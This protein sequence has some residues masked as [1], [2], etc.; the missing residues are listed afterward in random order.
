MLRVRIAGNAAL[1]WPTLLPLAVIE[2]ALLFYTLPHHSPWSDAGMIRAL[3]LPF[4]TGVTALTDPGPVIRV[5]RD[6]LYLEGWGDV[7]DATQVDGLARHRSDFGF[8]HPGIVFDGR[9]SVAAQRDVTVGAVRS[10]LRIAREN[11]YGN[12]Q[13]L[14]ETEY[15]SP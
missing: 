4:A 10:V 5:R 15:P 12:P 9:Y 7:D 6:G 3:G 8:F 14:V 13:L 2:L 11:G 1:P